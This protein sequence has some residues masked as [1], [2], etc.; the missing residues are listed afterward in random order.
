MA[1]YSLCDQAA[2][3]A[4][5]LTHVDITK[6]KMELESLAQQKELKELEIEKLKL[7][8]RIKKLSV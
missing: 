8:L 5:L 7:K 2:K 3:L 1:V 6:K 4:V